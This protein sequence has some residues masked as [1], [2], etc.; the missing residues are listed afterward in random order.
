[1]DREARD[2]LQVVGFKGET[3]S[4]RN[5]V[6]VIVSAVD[7]IIQRHSISYDSEFLASK[8]ATL[9]VVRRDGQTHEY[10][11]DI[12]TI[13]VSSCNQDNRQFDDEEKIISLTHE[14]M[15][16][17]CSSEKDQDFFQTYFG[18]DEFFTEYLTSQVVSKIGGIKLESYYRHNVRGYFNND[19][20]INFIKKSCDKVGYKPLL[21]SYVNREMDKVKDLVGEE[22]LAAMNDY[23]KYYCELYDQINRPMRVLNK[24]IE[25]PQFALQKETINNHVER[26][27]QSILT[28]QSSGK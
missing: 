13:Y 4:Y 3:E 10:V 28:H 21:E 18:F 23:Y 15:H 2:S 5:A 16:L 20:D 25:E 9:K 11:S 12:N 27:N 14:L 1:M 17:V 24:I 22:T 19:Q 6:D 7:G 26:I 8:V